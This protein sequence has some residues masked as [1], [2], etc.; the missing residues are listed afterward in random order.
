MPKHTK[1]H[2]RS[3]RKSAG[4]ATDKSVTSIRSTSSSLKGW[5]IVLLTFLM[6]MLAFTEAPGLNGPSY[7]TW[8]WRRLDLAQ[9]LV[10]LACGVPA[11]LTLVFFRYR[12]STNWILLAC[13]IVSSMALKLGCVLSQSNPIGFDYLSKV[14]WSPDA[15]SYY[16]DAARIVATAQ[17][18]GVSPTFWFPRYD[19]LVRARPPEGM[20]LHTITKPAGPLW[21]YLLFTWSMDYKSPTTM[22]VCSIALMLCSLVSIP[23]IYWCVRTVTDNPTVGLIAAA[24]VAVAP[25]FVLFPTKLDGLWVGLG[26][27][28][29]GTWYLALMRSRWRYSSLLGL[30]LAVILFVGFQQLTLGLFMALMPAIVIT[31]RPM[32]QRYGT[33]LKYGVP[34]IFLAIGL[35]VLLALTTGYNTWKVFRA[36]LYAQNLLLGLPELQ[37]RRAPWTTFWDLYDYSLGGGWVVAL[38]FLMGLMN[39]ELSP[40]IRRLGWA[41]A[42]LLGVIAVLALIPAETAR[43][44][45][46]LSAAPLILIAS[47]ANTWPRD[48]QTLLVGCILVATFI[49]HGKM[50]FILP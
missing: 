28:V 3:L 8:P 10:M 5:A 49:I 29:L 7:W 22:I 17:Q 1:Q 41:A 43:C 11:V 27:V 15:T 31:D 48:R 26:A 35:H 38:V 30:G 20:N 36:N 4:V 24:I 13:W 25:G 16:F 33:A 21:F 42:V 47:E 34:A 19:E 9:W 12:Q 23:A 37:S 50:A 2:V 32:V 40:V 44:W 14:T 18:D 6:A 46:F 45:L 39:F